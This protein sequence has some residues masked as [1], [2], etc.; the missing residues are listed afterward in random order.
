MISF[1]FFQDDS[2]PIEQCDERI[3]AALKD[4]TKQKSWG[5]GFTD[6]ALLTAN[7]NQLRYIVDHPDAHY[8]IPNTVLLSLSILLQVI[9]RFC[10]FSERLNNFHQYSCFLDHWGDLANS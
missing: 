1:Y 4:Y 10:L 7:A 9:I 2:L 6:L 5:K 8:R 3:K